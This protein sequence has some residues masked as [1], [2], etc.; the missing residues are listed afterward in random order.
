[1][2]SVRRMI[3]VAVNLGGLSLAVYQIG[4]LLQ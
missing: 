4:A 1:M 2:K 3:G